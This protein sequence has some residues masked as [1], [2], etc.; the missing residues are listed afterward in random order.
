MVDFFLI[1]V[2]QKMHKYLHDTK[3]VLVTDQ[4][5]IMQTPLICQYLLHPDIAPVVLGLHHYK[6]HDA[7]VDIMWAVEAMSSCCLL[8]RRH[9]LDRFMVHFAHISSNIYDTSKCSFQDISWLPTFRLLSRSM[10]ASTEVSD[11]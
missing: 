2:N 11:N 4:Y 1:F 3:P 8:F 5:Q 10:L 6:R 7:D 9:V